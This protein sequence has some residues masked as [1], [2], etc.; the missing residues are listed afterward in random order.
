MTPAHPPST[1][2]FIFVVLFAI[3][4]IAVLFRN[5]IRD[6]LDLYDLALLSAVG[7]VPLGFVLLPAWAEDLSRLVGVQFPFIILFGGLL[8]FAFL[9]LYRLLHAFAKLKRQVRALTQELALLS[10][11]IEETGSSGRNRDLHE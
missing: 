6:E 8:F 9:A 5:A 7:A 4:Y 2:T 3:V 10:A 1:A 11:R